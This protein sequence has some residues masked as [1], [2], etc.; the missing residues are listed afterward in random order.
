MAAAA[1]EATHVLKDTYATSIKTAHDYSAKVL[2]FAQIN[3]NSAFEYASQLAAVKSPTEF[4]SV[5]SNHMHQQI[6]TLSKQAQ[7]LAA[8]T[9]K[10]MTAAAES[11]KTGIHKAQ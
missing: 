5:S 8:I 4:F 3:A 10:M 7:E 6:E 9:Q 1:G 2:E 11:V